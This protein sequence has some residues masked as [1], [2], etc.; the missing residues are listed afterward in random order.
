MI[1]SSSAAMIRDLQ[2]VL[3]GIVA[4]GELVC[5]AHLQLAIDIL[6]QNDLAAEAVA[7]KLHQ[8]GALKDDSPERVQP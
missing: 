4:A 2:Y 1:R 6:Q 7:Q 8:I 3:D 5:A